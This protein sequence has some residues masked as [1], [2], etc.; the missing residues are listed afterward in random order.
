MA[1][2]NSLNLL[3]VISIEESLSSPRWYWV[4]NLKGVNLG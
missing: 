1:G 2:F 4:T 3:I